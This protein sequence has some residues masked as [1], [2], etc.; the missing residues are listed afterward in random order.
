LFE[1]AWKEG[2]RFTCRQCS[3]CCSGLPGL[4]WLGEDD[5]VRLTDGLGLDL[6]SFAAAYCR[7]VDVGNGPCLCLDEKP[8]YDCIFLEKGVCSVYEFRPTQCRTYPFWDE[9][10]ETPEAWDREAEACPGIGSGELRKPE[11]IV[12]CLQE[13]RKIRPFRRDVK[14]P[15]KVAI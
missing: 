6:D 4:V 9:I 14:T 12:E 2:L 11:E 8:G 3:S 7:S 10:V 5:V 15:G 1:A 13:Q